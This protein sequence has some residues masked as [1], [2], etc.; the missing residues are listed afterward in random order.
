MT[1]RA[2]LDAQRAH[3]ERILGESSDRFGID[4]SAH[5]IA[6]AEMFRAGFQ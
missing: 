3:W 4:A 2:V 1:E 5:A 6:A